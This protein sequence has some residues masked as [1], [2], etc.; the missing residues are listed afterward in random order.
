MS[1]RPCMWL[2]NSNEYSCV[3]VVYQSIIAAL[4]NRYES[5]KAYLESE[6]PAR[7]TDGREVQFRHKFFAYRCAGCPSTVTKLTAQSA[8]ERSRTMLA[9][10]KKED[11]ARSDWVFK[12]DDV[13][14]LSTAALARR[15][16]A[17]SDVAIVFSTDI[18][19]VSSFKYDQPRSCLVNS[20]SAPNSALESSVI[21]TSHTYH[22]PIRSHTYHISH[23]SQFVP[24][25]RSLIS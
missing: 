7:C 2:T 21:L 10:W 16:R 12:M 25:P 15:V 13:T 20:N 22:T 1:N 18:A 24:Y 19:I 17:T 5:I 11:S 14:W 9:S 8:F 4:H 23:P 6:Q 3:L